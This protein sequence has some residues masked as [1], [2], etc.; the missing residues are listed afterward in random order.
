[1]AIFGNTILFWYTVFLGCIIAIGGFGFL[2]VRTSVRDQVRFLVQERLNYV[3]QF[4]GKTAEQAPRLLLK[5]EPFYFQGKRNKFAGYFFT[6]LGIEVNPKVLIGLVGFL[7]VII[8]AFFL[9]YLLFRVYLA[10]IL[11]II[12]GVAVVC[13]WWILK[14]RR[15]KY[16]FDC[17]AQLPEVLDYI[18]R[19]LRAGHAFPTCISLVGEDLGSPLGPEFLRVFREQELGLTL[20]SSLL[21]LVQRVPIMDL[22]YFYTAYQVNREIGGN[23]A[24]VLDN[25]ARIIRERF[26]LKRH[27]SALTAEGRFSAVILCLLPFF[28]AFG[29]SLIRREYVGLLFTDPLGLKFLLVGIIFWFFGVIVIRRMVNI[30]Y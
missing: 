25:I 15:G 20:S 26:K 5:K 21:N 18:V 7:G 9:I 16:L 22:K 2:L 1:M 19:G 3:K 23:L 17:E 29:L 24:E 14:Y 27:V 13:A 28:V 10:L 30:E 6:Q 12:I 4:S 11:G 8:L